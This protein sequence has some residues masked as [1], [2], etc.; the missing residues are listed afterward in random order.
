MEHW[1]KHTD[2]KR[3]WVMEE[4]IKGEKERILGSFSPGNK[5]N[6]RGMRFSFLGILSM[7]GGGG[8]RGGG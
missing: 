3:G 8:G 6:I 5:K 7:G 2:R 4:E 1:G